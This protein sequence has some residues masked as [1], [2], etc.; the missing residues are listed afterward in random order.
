MYMNAH[1]SHIF[2]LADN[3]KPKKKPKNI[4]KVTKKWDASF[5]FWS[6]NWTQNGP[7]MGPEPKKCVRRRRRKRFLSFFAAVAV[8]SHSPNRFLEG[9]TLQNCIISTVGAR[10]WENHRL[11]KNTEKVASGDLFWDPKWLNIDA[12]ATQNRQKWRKKL[13]FDVPFFQR[14]F[15]CEKKTKKVE[16]RAP[17]PP[18][19]EGSA[20][21]RRP[22][23]R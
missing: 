23:G 11:R 16:K 1:S 22:P 17:D 15:A 19:P 2:T 21:L 3:K 12:G 13:I 10:F 5:R 18:P 20:V 14:F 9:P 8:R 6:P 7:K 4:K